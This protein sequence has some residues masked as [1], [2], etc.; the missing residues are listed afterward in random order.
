MDL[1]AALKFLSDQAVRSA[2]PPVIDHPPASDRTGV[3]FMRQP[4]G[5]Y[6]PNNLPLP[7][8]VGTARDLAAIAELVAEGVAGKARVDVWYSCEKVEA[9]LDCGR[10]GHLSL[11]VGLSPQAAWLLSAEGAGKPLAQ[12]E[13]VR[14]FRIVLANH[15]PGNLLDCLRNLSFE[16]LN[17]TEADIQHGKASLGKS[18]QAKTGGAAALPER[19]VVDFPVFKSPVFQYRAS[20]ALDLEPQAQAERLLFTVPPGEVAAAICD[21]EGKLGAAVMDAIKARQG[22]DGDGDW[23]IFYGV[24]S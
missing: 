3:F 10:R 18:I 1:S 9:F 16:V 2:G 23:K 8:V 4:D 21:A 22:G 5:S 14:H 7:G 13:A 17:K 15:S 12:A 24:S 20:V 19:V 11:P 6:Q